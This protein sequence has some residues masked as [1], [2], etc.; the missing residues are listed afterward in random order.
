M[1]VNSTDSVNQSEDFIW[2]GSFDRDLNYLAIILQ[3]AESDSNFKA[4]LAIRSLDPDES[5]VIIEDQLMEVDSIFTVDS[6][7]I[8]QISVQLKGSIEDPSLI[9]VNE[10]NGEEI[11]S[12]DQS[13]DFVSITKAL[14]DTFEVEDLS[15]ISYKLGTRIQIRR[16]EVT[17][18]QTD[19][20]I[21]KMSNEEG[22]LKVFKSDGDNIT[23]NTYLTNGA[24]VEQPTSS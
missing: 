18:G 24:W 15:Q 12:Q 3:K 13:E 1:P 9:L 5:S 23:W 14:L 2:E 22:A 17:F 21:F 4:S 10:T 7:G 19:E 8:Q 20:E 6:A 16:D 11:Y